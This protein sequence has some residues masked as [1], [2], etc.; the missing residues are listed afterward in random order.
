MENPRFGKFFFTLTT[1]EISVD[2]CIFLSLFYPWALPEQS[3]IFSF[4]VGRRVRGEWGC[5]ENRSKGSAV[6]TG[7]LGPQTCDVVAVRR[8]TNRKIH[9][10]SGVA[11]KDTH[12]WIAVPIVQLAIWAAVTEYHLLTMIQSIHLGVVARINKNGF[13]RTTEQSSKEGSR[14]QEEVIYGVARVP[15]RWLLMPLGEWMGIFRFLNWCI[16]I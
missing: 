15:S 16:A 4:F 2:N 11:G 5:R 3:L 10:K 14:A 7:A 1:L 9:W 8:M 12:R 13:V 6:S